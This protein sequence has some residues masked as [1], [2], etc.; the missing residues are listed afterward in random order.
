MWNVII[1]QL[2]KSDSPPPRDL[3]LLPGSCSFLF[4]WSLSQTVFARPVFPVVC[5]VTAS[6][7]SS[8]QGVG[9]VTWR[10]GP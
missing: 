2:W 5:V 1:S 7:A 10:R 8:S 9:G 3:H 4:L 6:S